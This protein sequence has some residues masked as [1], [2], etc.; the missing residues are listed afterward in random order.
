MMF[1][2]DIGINFRT[3]FIHPITDVIII[4]SR[5]I[6][7]RYL[8][9]WFFIDFIS[10]VP[11]DYIFPLFLDSSQAS[12]SIARTLKTFSRCFG[13]LRLF[14]VARLTRY[15]GNVEQSIADWKNKLS[16]KLRPCLECSVCS[17]SK[18]T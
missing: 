3:G 18:K 1:M 13:F 5:A 10:S 15:L 16:K 2:V 12:S 4:D 6:V 11:F 17:K 14:R 9:G 8:R 7:K